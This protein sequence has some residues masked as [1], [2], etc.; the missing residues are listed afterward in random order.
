MYD[1]YVYIIL[2]IIQVRVAIGSSEEIRK[3]IKF[4]VYDILIKYYFFTFDI[5]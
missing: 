3:F 4:K 1:K 2:G 5:Y